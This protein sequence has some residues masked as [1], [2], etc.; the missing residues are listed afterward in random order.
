MVILFAMA[1]E[2]L[3]QRLLKP[4]ANRIDIRSDLAHFALIQYAVPKV[5][6]EPHIP[7]ERFIIPEFEIAGEKKALLSV[8]PFLDEDFNF[9]R[10]TPFW[11]M[12]FA[13]TNHRVYVIDRQTGEP[14]VWF[15]GTTLGS[16][17]V[18][19]AQWLWQIPWHFASY[20]MDCVYD[21]A[22]SRY[23][24]Y[25]IQ[26]ESDW[27]GGIID[28]DDTGKPIELCTG[29]SSMDEMM[30]ILTHPVQGYYWCRNGR[31]GGYSVWHEIM[32]LTQGKPKNIY[33][34]LYE[35][36]GILSK[37]EM[38]TPHSIFI[39]PNITFDVHMPPMIFED[40]AIS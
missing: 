22:E 32:Q 40:S 26:M 29:F 15:L 34:S 37:E 21:A 20:Q 23:K 9:Y 18:H 8:V 6:L 25:N 33:L 39:C 1:Q 28:I 16:R 24:S 10:L 2:I 19:P 14:V 12:Q 11:K 38:Q 3:T 31:L 13:Q 5:R 30:L 7:Q 36:L 4:A 17:I 27:C 35:R